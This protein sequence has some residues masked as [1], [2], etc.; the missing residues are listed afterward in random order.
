MTLTLHNPVSQA[1]LDDLMDRLTA[2]LALTPSEL[3]GRAWTD[4]VI[5]TL[6]ETVRA[7]DQGALSQAAA[8]EVFQTFR[9][10]GF[11]FEQWLAEMIEEGI[12]L[13]TAHL[14]AA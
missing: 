11:R 8:R 7:M 9:I 14:Q 12:Y 10:P 5:R 3:Y 13:E 6:I 4:Q 1:H 2:Q